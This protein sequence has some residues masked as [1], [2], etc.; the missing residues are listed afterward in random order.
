MSFV[1]K[2]IVNT[3]SGDRPLRVFRATIPIRVTVNTVVDAV[4]I[5]SANTIL[6][7]VF[8]PYGFNALAASAPVTAQPSSLATLVLI[9][10]DQPLAIQSIRIS[11]SAPL[12]ANFTL[13]FYRVDGT[14]VAEKPTA[15]A[16]CTTAS[17]P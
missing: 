14:T 7:G 9:T 2:K 17:P 6:Q 5:D 8:E 15:I 4:E 12:A 3:P 10:L 13:A 16:P 11:Q 1:A